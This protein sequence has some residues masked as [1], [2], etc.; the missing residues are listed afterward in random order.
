MKTIHVAHNPRISISPCVFFSSLV[1]YTLMIATYLYYMIHT[2]LPDIVKDNFRWF[3]LPEIT[4]WYCV[5][6]IME[7]DK[8]FRVLQSY[9]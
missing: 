3:T 1:R 5:V 4:L 8:V 7:G 6:Y 2:E 9:S